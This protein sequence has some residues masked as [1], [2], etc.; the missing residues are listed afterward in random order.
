[1]QRKRE[2]GVWAPIALVIFC[3]ALFRLV[4]DPPTEDSSALVLLEGEV[5]D[6]AKMRS[7]VRLS[8]AVAQAVRLGKPIV[9]L[10][11]TVVTHGGF[12]YAHDV[13]FFVKDPQTDS[14]NTVVT[15]QVGLSPQFGDGKST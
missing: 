13:C 7:L 3:F 9:A 8:P 15:P 10:E 5:P 11:S 6:P 2:L 12:V 1:M 4:F 14:R